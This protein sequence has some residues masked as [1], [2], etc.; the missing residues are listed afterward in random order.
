MNV[1]REFALGTLRLSTGR[2]TT[3]GEVER[4]AE[5]ILAEARKQRDAADA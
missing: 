4:A 1:P 5:L 2:H 3:M